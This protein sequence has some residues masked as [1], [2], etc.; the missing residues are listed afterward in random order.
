MKEAEMNLKDLKNM[1]KSDVLGLLG[2]EQ[3]P[4]GTS[5]VLRSLGLIGIGALIGA[6][7]G[8]LMAPSSGRELRDDLSKR[9]KSGTDRALEMTN[10]AVD[11]V[12]EV[13]A[14]D[15]QT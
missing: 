15:G 13:T 14:T 5:Q 7:A 9:I 12:R 3:I 11:R 10:E 2:L 6:T 1:D 4:S 8:L